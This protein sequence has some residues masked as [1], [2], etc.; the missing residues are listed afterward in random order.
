MNI[1][2]GD[3]SFH[4]ALCAKYTWDRLTNSMDLER[5][6]KE[7]TEF[8]VNCAMADEESTRKYTRQRI[9]LLT[10][11]EPRSFENFYFSLPIIF[12]IHIGNIFLSVDEKIRYVVIS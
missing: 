1:Y 7:V 3:P 8:R 9:F 2:I 6:M 11:I 10:T 5:L 12:S 4:E